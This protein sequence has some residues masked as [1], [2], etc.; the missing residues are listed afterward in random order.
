LVPVVFG[1][2]LRPFDQIMI[3]ATGLAFRCEQAESLLEAE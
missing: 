2:K 3:G 1:Q